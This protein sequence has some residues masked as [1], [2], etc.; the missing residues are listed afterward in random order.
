[1]VAGRSFETSGSLNPVTQ[2]NTPEQQNYQHQQCGNLKS[3]DELCMC[4]QKERRR[5]KHSV[6][7]R[8]LSNVEQIVFRTLP[9]GGSKQCSAV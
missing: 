2:R 3:K 6:L 5:Q 1:M 8:T 9:V 4:L 7:K